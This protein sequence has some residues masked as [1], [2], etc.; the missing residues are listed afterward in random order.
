MLSHV[1]II[2][3][4]GRCWKEHDA[5]LWHSLWNLERR[6][7]IKDLAATDEHEQW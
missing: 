4:D 1:S 7:A 5:R 2:S 6:T 3:A